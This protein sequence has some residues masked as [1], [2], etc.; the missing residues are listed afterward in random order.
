MQFYDCRNHVRVIQPMGD[1]SR[2]YV[3][4]T[5]AHN[6]KDWV[7]NVSTHFNKNFFFFFLLT[8]K[9][10]KKKMLEIDVYVETHF[11][12]EEVYAEVR[13]GKKR[14]ADHDLCYNR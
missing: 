9:L 10:K 4:G 5:N 8:G 14:I 7:I 12:M 11:R 1:G 3:C 13:M 2:L 6:P